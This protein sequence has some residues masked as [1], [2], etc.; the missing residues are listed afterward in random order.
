MLLV[1][2]I[3][4]SVFF[5]NQYSTKVKAIKYQENLSFE[6]LDTLD[7]F[8]TL[9]ISKKESNTED[10]HAE[11]CIPSTEDFLI[12]IYKWNDKDS[13]DAFAQH[14]QDANAIMNYLKKT[15]YIEGNVESLEANK[16]HIDEMK[17]VVFK[18]PYTV[19]EITYKSELGGTTNHSQFGIE[20]QFYCIKHNVFFHEITIEADPLP[21]QFVGKGYD[22]FV[23]DSDVDIAI[24]EYF[25]TLYTK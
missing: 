4:V 19:R 8:N 12:V 2:A 6:I 5:F 21:D 18:K 24:K 7:L 10:N 23:N 9:K 11:H 25:E 3:S 20:C 15:V 22:S 14:P 16:L 1:L 13:A 17:T